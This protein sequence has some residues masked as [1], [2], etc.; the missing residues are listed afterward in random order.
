[1][2]CIVGC[3]LLVGVLF[4]FVCIIINFYIGEKQIF[5]VVG[6]VVI[7]VVSGV[8]IGI[9]ILDSVKEC[10]ECV[11]VGV[12]IGVIVGGGVGYYMDVQ[13]VKL[14]QKLEGLGVFVICNGE[15][16]I[17]NMLGNVIFDIDSIQVKFLFCLVLDFVF[18]VF[19]EYDFIMLQIVG[20]ID[21]IGGDCYNLLFFQQCVQVVVDVFSGFGVQVVCMD[22]VGFGEIQLIV[23]NSFVLGCQQNCCVEFILIFYKE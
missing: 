6:G 18:E 7:G 1:M 23:D 2:K 5:K 12:G 21:S 10:K 13:E 3:L 16:I 22:V 19:K 15:N 9:V 4:L 20:Y 14:C 17:F 8:L 11:L